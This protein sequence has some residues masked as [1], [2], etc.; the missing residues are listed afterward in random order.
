M[1]IIETVEALEALYEVPNSLSKNYLTRRAQAF[2]SIAESQQKGFRRNLTRFYE[3]RNKF[4][5]GGMSIPHLLANEWLDPRAKESF[6]DLLIQRDFGA[7][8]VIATIQ[9]MITRSITR[10][11]FREQLVS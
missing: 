5:H 8:V 4:A 1:Q 7:R 6:R 3:N 2:L 11:E 10:I 9:Q